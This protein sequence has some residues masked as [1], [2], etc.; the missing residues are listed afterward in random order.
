[1]NPLIEHKLLATRRHLL[2]SMAGGIGAVALA[3]LLA[4]NAATAATPPPT[5][6]EPLAARP[7]PFAPRAKRIIAIPPP[8]PPPPPDPF[9]PQPQV[10]PRDPQDSPAA[11]TV[12]HS[13]VHI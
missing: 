3:D 4:E 6:T 10:V 11:T 8:G 9:H 7:P 2:G 1:M 12:R 13:F 5:A